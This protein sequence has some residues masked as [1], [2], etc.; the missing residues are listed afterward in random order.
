MFMNEMETLLCSFFNCYS[1][2]VQYQESVK[3]G[4]LR[5]CTIINGIETLFAALGAQQ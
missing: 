2:R 3:N 4:D 5:H 1:G